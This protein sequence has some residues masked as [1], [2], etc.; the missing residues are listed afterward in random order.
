MTDLLTFNRFRDTI[1]FSR[2]QDVTG[3]LSDITGPR[4]KLGI[5][6][7][8]FIDGQWTKVRELRI[9]NEWYNVTTPCLIA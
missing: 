6:S 9:N 3:K 2:N 8:V 7:A 1:Y 4:N 5:F